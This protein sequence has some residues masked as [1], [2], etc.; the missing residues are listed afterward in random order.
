[1]SPV[2][3]LGVL[4]AAFAGACAGGLPVL[5][6]GLILRGGRVAAHATYALFLAEPVDPDA[7]DLDPIPAVDLAL[8]RYLRTAAWHP[9]PRDEPIGPLNPGFWSYLAPRLSRLVR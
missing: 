1:M 2:R 4:L 5:P 9:I 8:E 7:P 3:R 6:F